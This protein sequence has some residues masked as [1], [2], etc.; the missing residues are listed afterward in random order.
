MDEPTSSIQVRPAPAVLIPES[1]EARALRRAREAEARA[2]ALAE[3]KARQAEMDARRARG[4]LPIPEHAEVLRRAGL[5]DQELELSQAAVEAQQRHVE[6]AQHAVILA[7]TVN[8]AAT[9]LDYLGKNELPELGGLRQFK[10][11]VEKDIASRRERDRRRANTGAA[12]KRSRA[13]ERDQLLREAMKKTPA[14]KHE[15]DAA[16]ARRLSAWLRTNRPGAFTRLFPPKYGET[17]EPC[18][19]VSPDAVRRALGK[20]RR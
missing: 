6:E 18:P 14:G 3:V 17:G 16:C 2:R 1:R 20:K 15:S 5:T 10:V 9:I 13:N 19:L 12:G 11:A 4:E 8:A 7:R